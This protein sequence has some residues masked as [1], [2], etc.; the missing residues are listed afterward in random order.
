MLQPRRMPHAEEALSVANCIE[1]RVTLHQPLVQRAAF[2]R[3]ERSA[4]LQI[5]SIRKLPPSRRIHDAPANPA[6]LPSM[7]VFDEAMP[8]RQ[9]KR[10]RSQLDRQ[11]VRQ[12]FR[13]KMNPRLAVVPYV[14][15]HVKEVVRGDGFEQPCGNFSADARTH[16][17]H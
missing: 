1:R 14:G 3:R 10:A 7:L 8:I 5:G 6:C 15:S 4:D 16:I 2:A 17:L 11:P 12:P 13:Q 9:P